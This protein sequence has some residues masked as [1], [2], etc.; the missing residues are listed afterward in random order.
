MT[1]LA[2]EPPFCKEGV[3]MLTPLMPALLTV[4]VTDDVIP[5]SSLLI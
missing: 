3:G 4:L 1:L 2:D 5:L